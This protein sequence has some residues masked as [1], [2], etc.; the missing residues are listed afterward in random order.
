M[1]EAILLNNSEMC[2]LE[3]MNVQKSSQNMRESKYK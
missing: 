1:L 2:Y 3:Q